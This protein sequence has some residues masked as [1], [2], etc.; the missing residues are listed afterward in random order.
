MS[1]VAQV[2]STKSRCAI[3]SKRPSALLGALLSAALLAQPGVVQAQEPAGGPTAERSVGSNAER[4]DAAF[5]EGRDL[6]DQGRFREACEK[7]EVS[8]QL[9][10]S[11]GTL[12]N[13]GNCYEPQGDLVRALST[14]ERAF[15][16]AQKSPDP[17]RREMWSNAA[18]ERIASLTAR[19]PQLSVRGAQPG[20]LVSID[21]QPAAAGVMRINPGHHTLKASAPG[22]RSYQQEFDIA[23]T[24][25]IA[26]NL[27]P[28]DP[29]AGANAVEPTPV[30]AEPPPPSE[31]APSQ[32]GV[33]PYVLGGSGAA[34]LGTSL[35]T[36]LMAS[37]KA[38]RLDR[39]CEDKRCNASLASVK[40]SAE[41]LAL[42]T[43]VLWI[44]GAV[45]AGV[46][47]TL[48]VLD[49]G[50]SESTA[51]LQTGCYD[52]ACGLFASG[53]F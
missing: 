48:F 27:P 16:D 39:D 22:K 42:V 41:T 31:P 17:Q 24:Q 6:F 26:I 36:G 29:E 5:N 30:M 14:F 34:L 38:H 47:V 3:P 49:N 37:S 20:T 51:A 45:V 32:Y 53:R 15:S 10:P 11:P 7:F 23:A 2:G 35:V 21:D 13:L 12:L 50:S 33:W 19:V 25:R 52:A 40:D 43:D 8:L 4:A 46:G 1:D 18:R 28:L 44:T 9:D